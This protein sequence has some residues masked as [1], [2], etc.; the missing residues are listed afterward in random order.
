M[1]V[2]PSLCLRATFPALTFINVYP[3]SQY[4]YIVG[5]EEVRRQPDA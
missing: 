3:A 1:A 2:S 4:V 5:C